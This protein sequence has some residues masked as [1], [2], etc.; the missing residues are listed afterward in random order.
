[1][2]LN[3]TQVKTLQPGA[4]ADGGGLCLHVRKSGE[5]VWAFRFTAPDGKRAVMEF[6]KVSDLGL[7]DARDQAREYRLA[8]KKDGV[9]P[10]HKKK[11]EAAGGKT[12]KAYWEEKAPGWCAGKNEDETKAW[13]RSLRDISSLHE[14]KL[15]E[16]DAPHVVEALEAIWYE[17]PITAN[18]TR[19]RIEKVL[20]AAK[21]EKYRSGDN[22]AA[23]RG[24]LKFVLPSARKLNK[25]RGHASVPYA[26]APALM[27]ELHNDPGRV[28]RCVEVGDSDGS[29]IAG[30]P[31]DG[32]DRDRLGEEDVAMP[33]RK[34]EDQ[35]RRRRAPASGA[36][37]QSGHR[38]H[39]VHAAARPLRVPV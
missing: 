23:W 37:D 32:M 2:P 18:R 12:F 28:A 34:N 1:M 29:P 13:G 20:D 35:R 22:P 21:V 26:K 11:I 4:Y 24:N 8:L 5:R 30:D 9:D 10:R 31:A 25:K 36:L 27:V 39:R 3:A 15:H 38:D 17:K 16:I 14:L 6:A 19:E 33:G 7:S